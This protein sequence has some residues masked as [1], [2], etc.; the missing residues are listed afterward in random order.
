ME[1]HF[2]YPNG[3]GTFRNQLDVEPH[4]YAIQAFRMVPHPG[5][6]YGTMG[7]SRPDRSPTHAEFAACWTPSLWGISYVMGVLESP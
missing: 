1:P 2:S 5:L 4:E 7:H 6:G 3:T